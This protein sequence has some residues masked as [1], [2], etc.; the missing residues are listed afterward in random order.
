MFYLVEALAIETW[1]ENNCCNNIKYSRRNKSVNLGHDTF[2]APSPD[3]SATSPNSDRVSQ[4]EATEDKRIAYGKA[5]AEPTSLFESGCVI[6]V[7][8]HDR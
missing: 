4:G 8:R 1:L 7:A 5:P 3:A 6:V 2:A